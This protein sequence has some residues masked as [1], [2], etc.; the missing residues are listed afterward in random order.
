MVDYSAGKKAELPNESELST[1][2]ELGESQVAL[3]AAIAAAEQVVAD[4][5][6]QYTLLRCETLPEA[7]KQ[8][9]LSE[10][11]LANGA[12]VSIK[13]EYSVSIANANKPAAFGWLRKNGH[14]DI[15]KN[16]V[17]LSFGMGEDEGKDKAIDFAEEHDYSYAAKEAVHAG[18]L[19]AWAKKQ[20]ELQLDDDPA[21]REKGEVPEELITVFRLNVSKVALPKVRAPR[22]KRK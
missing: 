18:T 22:A 20:F 19:K 2:S 16:D 3:E 10:F 4:L 1:I 11:T 9:G 7:M 21:V 6:T 17:T 13:E 12:K 5:K 14:G 15:I 8:V